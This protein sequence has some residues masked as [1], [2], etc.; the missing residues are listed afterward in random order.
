MPSYKGQA[1]RTHKED[2]HVGDSIKE[3]GDAEEGALVGKVVV[4]LGLWDGGRVNTSRLPLPSG[5]R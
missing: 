4:G 1:Q 2:R 5:Q 3:I